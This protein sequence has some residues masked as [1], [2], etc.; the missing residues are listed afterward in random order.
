[1]RTEQ[2]PIV[3]AVGDALLHP[4]AMHL[5]AVT[6]RPVIDISEPADLTRHIARAFAVL[7]DDTQLDAITPPT[8]TAVPALS[9]HPGVIR[10]CNQAE[11]GGE[12][13][14]A[15]EAQAATVV[16]QSFMLPAQAADLL[17][18]FGTLTLTPAAPAVPAATGLVLSFVGAAGGAGT[19]TLAAAV[20]RVLARE[21]GGVDPVVV[22]AHTYS[23]GLDLLLGVEDEVG[24]R[25][26][27][28]QI[29][30][31]SV[32]R[33]TLVKA[34]P[35][36]ADGIAVLTH[37]RTAV[38][39]QTVP[40]QR[41]DKRSEELERVT[42]VL[43]AAGVTVIDAAPDGQPARTDHTF[44]VTPAEVRATAVA[45]RIAAECRA[46]SV[47]ASVVLR[48]RA[49]SG[50]SAADVGEVTKTE[51]VAEVSTVRSL[52]KETEL[53]GLPTR[54]PRSLAAAVKQIVEV[55]G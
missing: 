19:S 48:H 4:E 36:T 39:G 5:A 31:G 3:V 9:S 43:G 33:S 7:I 35:R 20:A 23:G 32:D 11:I 29:G 54:L 10:V 37:G 13:W 40:G 42:A 44:I 25:W 8:G 24:A 6:G 53:S 16:K 15:R 27:D 18:M 41:G 22:D 12:G 55:V 30:D 14:Q 2:A 47:P 52:T 21:V 45:A 38:P 28:L 49:W 50:M 17:K 51:V 26:G 1:M 46:S 34:L